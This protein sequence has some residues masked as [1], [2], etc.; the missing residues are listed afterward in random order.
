MQRKPRH[1]ITLLIALL[2]A[3]CYSDSVIR[4]VDLTAEAE[5][6]AHAI[7][8]DMQ[9]RNVTKGITAMDQTQHYEFGVFA[10]LENYYGNADAQH[11]MANYLVANG[12]SD[13][14]Q[15]WHPQASK[16]EQN[17]LLH[18][19]SDWVYTTLGYNDPYAPTTGLTSPLTKSEVPQQITKYWDKNA[20]NY[21]FFAYAPYMQQGIASVPGSISITNNQGSEVLC[22]NGLRAFYTHPAND[23]LPTA[24]IQSYQT[25]I[26]QGVHTQSGYRDTEDIAQS[27]AEIINANE[28]LYAGTSVSPE[29]YNANVPIIFKHINAKVCLAFWE[30]LKGYD[31]EI[32][33]LVP[34]DV[35]ITYGKGQPT[36]K[37]IALTP[38]TEIQTHY[39][40]PQASKQELSPYYAQA[41]VTVE[42]IA[43]E[44]LDSRTN[45]TRI[46]VG[47]DGV[48]DVSRENLYF[49][50][51]EG[52]MVGGTREAVTFSPTVYY[53]LPNYESSLPTPA[54]ITNYIN[55]IQVASQTGFTAHVTF[56]LH[57]A[58]GSHPTK[59]YDARAYVPAEKCQ[60]EAGKQ[61]IYVFKITSKVNGT[62][63]P[64]SPDPSDPTTPWVDPDDPR[65]PDTPALNPIVFDGLVVGDY[66]NKVETT[67]FEFKK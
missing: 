35:S 32:L 48:D 47:R 14:Y 20:G 36:V 61:Y 8:F 18:S 3:S 19:P 42:G 30:D 46:S 41:Q 7:T 22:F 39:P 38:A 13:A 25:G 5:Q 34:E 31:V 53:P 12:R 44:S 52:G 23:G 54:Y 55:G 29:I 43:P 51:P 40:A 59:V 1:I 57:P 64:N 65:I 62:T 9:A 50:I 60:W 49:A 33:D 2:L 6:Q 28:A 63:D 11:V 4:K 56:R 67:D 37:G 27:D 58:D 10:S 24:H 16:D 21:Y 26:T 66:E 15:P 17:T 45:F